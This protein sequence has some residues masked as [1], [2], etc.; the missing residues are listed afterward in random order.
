MG[1]WD[2]DA[3]VV[4]SAGVNDR[5]WLDRVGHPYSEKLRVTE[6]FLRVDCGHIQ[7][8]ITFDDP[9]TLT[10]PISRSLTLNYSADT[11]MLEA[12]CNENNR[13]PGHLVGTA[14]ARAREPT[15]L[16]QYVGRYSFR[17]GTR[18][19]P[20]FMGATQTVTPRRY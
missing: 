5:T 19:I 17:D 6:R 1:H 13:A 8:Q 11:D 7:Y 18:A 16:A 10:A 14:T 4:E 12:V 3:L 20:T 9:D 15:S 2:G